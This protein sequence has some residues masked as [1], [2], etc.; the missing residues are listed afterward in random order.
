MRRNRAGLAAIAWLAGIGAI[1]G[2]SVFVKQVRSKELNACCL[3]PSAR[4]EQSL[5]G[6]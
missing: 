5:Y 2:Q 6:L 3:A 1:R 4:S